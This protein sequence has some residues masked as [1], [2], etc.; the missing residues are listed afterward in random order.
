MKGRG[1]EAR[2]KPRG[3][4]CVE[5]RGLDGREKGSGGAYRGQERGGAGPRVERKV[6][7]QGLDK[8]GEAGEAPGRR[9]ES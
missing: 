9:E 6:E 8:R 4:A 3:R 7:G 2:G 1:L 5:G